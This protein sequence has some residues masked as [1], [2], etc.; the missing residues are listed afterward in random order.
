MVFFVINS[1]VSREFEEHIDEVETE[2]ANALE[3]ASESFAAI[4]RRVQTLSPDECIPDAVELV[5]LGYPGRSRQLADQIFQAS[6][7]VDDHPD[8]ILKAYR[9][10][11]L[12]TPPATRARQSIKDCHITESY[13]R[14]LYRWV[15]SAITLPVSDRFHWSQGL[16]TSD[17]DPG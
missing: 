10:V 9:R 12:A 5:S 11:R 14:G 2:T 1:Q 13:L 16:G 8:D 15:D 4:L 7:V 3:K 6:S 17:S